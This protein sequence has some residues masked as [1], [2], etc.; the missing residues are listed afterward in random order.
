MNKLLIIAATT[1]LVSPAFAKQY[2][3]PAKDQTP[4]QQAMD[5]KSCDGWAAQQTGAS[6]AELD[7]QV[8]AAKS[9]AAPGPEAQASAGAGGRGAVRGAI[10]G[11][12]I[13]HATDNDR[14]DA[15][16]I[17]AVVGAA[18]SN[19]RSAAANSQAQAQAQ[20]EHVEVNVEKIEAQRQEYYKARTSCLKGKGYTVE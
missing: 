8:A 7:S 5:E 2:V 6:P 3:F 1:L 12:A 19:R 17:G 15:A 18:R 10:V 13:G 20:A 4:E 9:P 16:A 14:S 11:S